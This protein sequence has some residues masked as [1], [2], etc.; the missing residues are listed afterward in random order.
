MSDG[1]RYAYP[2]LDRLLHEPARLSLLTALM[3]NPAGLSFA[4]LQAS[5]GLTDGNLA[6]HVRHLDGAGLVEPDKR[7]EAGRVVTIYRITPQGQARF[8]AYLDVLQGVIRDASP[9]APRRSVK[10]R[11]A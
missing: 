2:G 5:C 11:L 10:T 7:L 3:T 1:A 8:V 4:Q 6:S 9:A